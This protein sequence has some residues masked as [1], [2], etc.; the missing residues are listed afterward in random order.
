MYLDILSNYYK[1]PQ[2]MSDENIHFNIL[3]K[4][5]FT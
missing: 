1:N 5:T 4:Y 3:K 2:N